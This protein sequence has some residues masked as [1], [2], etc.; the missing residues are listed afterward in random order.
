MIEKGLLDETRWLIN[1]EYNSDLPSMS[2][3][4]YKQ[5]VMYLKG[6]LSLD[7]A[8]QQIKYETHRYVRSQ[9]NWFKLKDDRIKWFDVQNEVESDIIRAIDDFISTD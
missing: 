8:I 4:G 1:N 7:S 3:I 2:G 9:Y 6:E 5:M